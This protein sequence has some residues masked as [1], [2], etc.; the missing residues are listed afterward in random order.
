MRPRKRGSHR[1]KPQGVNLVLYSADARTHWV[2][3]GHP[4]TQPTA[5]PC[6]SSKHPPSP[7]QSPST[8]P[9]ATPAETSLIQPSH[10]P[11]LARQSTFPS[12]A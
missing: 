2:L 11:R 3:P 9:A 1:P 7:R 6:A 4:C 5:V 12:R 8:V 10:S